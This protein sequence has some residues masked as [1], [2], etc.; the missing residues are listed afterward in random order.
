ME[1]EK[2]RREQ[3]GGWVICVCCCC[4]PQLETRPLAYGPTIIPTFVAYALELAHRSPIGN[5][6]GTDL[7]NSYRDIAMSV[8]HIECMLSN[9]GR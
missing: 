4:G 8:V 3:C 5:F 2:I 9:K 1:E 7:L 6:S